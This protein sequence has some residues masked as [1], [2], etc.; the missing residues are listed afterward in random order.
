MRDP[1]DL[2]DLDVRWAENDWLAESRWQ[3]RPLRDALPDL[4]RRV[5]GADP[6]GRFGI[7]SAGHLV[8]GHVPADGRGGR[9]GAPGTPGPGRSSTTAPGT[10][11]S[12]SAPAGARATARGPGGRHAPRGAVTGAYIALLGPADA[13]HHWQVTLSPGDAFTTVPVSGRRQ[14]RRVRGRRGR[15]HRRPPRDPPPARR[16]P[17]SPGDLQRLHEHADGRPHHRAAAAADRRRGRR[18]ARSTSASTPAGTRRS[19]R[20]GGTRSAPGSPPAPGSPDGIAEV[21]DHIRA[22][23]MVPGLWLEPEVVGRPQPGRRAAAGRRVLPARRPASWSSTAATT[24][25]CATRPR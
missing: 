22:A 9:T 4:N 17:A 18:R 13:E 24:W 14:P 2:G 6:R 19:T 12:A 10:G 20:A 3:S 16:P 1:D 11:R 5:H 23:G 25:T 8:I 21:L 15:A 7:T